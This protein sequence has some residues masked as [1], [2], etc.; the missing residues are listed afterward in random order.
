MIIAVALDTGGRQ[1]VEPHVALSDDDLAARRELTQLASMMGWSA[2]LWARIAAP[3]YPVLIDEEHRVADLFGMTNVP[4]AVWID[5][6]GRIVRP[7]ETAGFGDNHK[8]MDRE[9]FTVP[10]EDLQRLAANRLHYMNAIR[11]WVRDGADSVYALDPDEVRRRTRRPEERDV[12]AAVHARLGRL[13]FGEGHH[14]AAKHYFREATALCPEK[15][16]YRRQAMVLEPELVGQLNTS[17]EFFEA[18]DALGDAPYQTPIE[19]P[20]IIPDEF[21]RT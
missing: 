17:P 1:A 9:T 4:Q 5:E 19:M 16:N 6:A 2:E 13:L 3:T 8:N 15:W 20:G 10:E 14:D 12:H 11:D 7:A 18:Q 21:P